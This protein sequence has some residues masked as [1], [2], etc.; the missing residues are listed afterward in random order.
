MTVS[1][2]VSLSLLGCL[3]VASSVALAA[4]ASA[5]SPSLSCKVFPSSFPYRTGVC[6]TSQA[7]TTYLIDNAVANGPASGYDWSVPSGTKVVGGCNSTSPFC[8]LSVRANSSD[9]D[10]TTQVTVPGA[11]TL[12]VVAVIPAVCGAFIC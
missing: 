8:S 12:S 2:L 10:F 4:P 5:A 11:G 3:A 7:A 1:K 9:R 6:G